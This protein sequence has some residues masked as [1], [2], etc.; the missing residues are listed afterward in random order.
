[1]L[2]FLVLLAIASQATASSNRTAPATKTIVDLAL[3]TPSLST[4]VTAL[5]TGGLVKTLQG[6]GPYT[7]FA[8]TNAAFS[9][10]PKRVLANLLKPANKAKLVDLL[11][12]HVVAGDIQAKDILDGERIKTVEGMY[13]MASVNSSGVF[14]NNAK[15]I[16][17]NVNA[18][19]GVV[20]I[21]NEELDC[22]HTR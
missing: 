13:L 8:P 10:L 1:M 15:V 3:A 6:P 22:G 20:H 12:F 14:L 11:T 2:Q 21:I 19:N 7:V 4:L 9:A 18:S 16:T 17:P 5:Q